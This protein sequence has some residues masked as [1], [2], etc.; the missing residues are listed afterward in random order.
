MGSCDASLIAV[1]FMYTIDWVMG[2]DGVG[3]IHYW[4][5]PFKFKS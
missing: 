5:I 3:N 1:Y 2:S 4:H